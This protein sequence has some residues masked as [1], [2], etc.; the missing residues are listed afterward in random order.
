MN[1]PPANLPEL[2]QCMFLIWGGVVPRPRLCPVTKPFKPVP[3]PHPTM[4]GRNR[5]P[6]ALRT[7]HFIRSPQDSYTRNRV[8]ISP[9]CGIYGPCEV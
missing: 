6:F 1:Q 3:P 2:G 4:L 7:P 8:Q 5:R 9:K